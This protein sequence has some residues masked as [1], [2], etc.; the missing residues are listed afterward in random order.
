[1]TGIELARNLLQLKPG[2]PIILCTGFSETI[3]PEIAKSAGVKDLIMKPFKRRQIA[4]S[5]R[6]TLDSK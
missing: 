5:I 6:R 1:M 2:I 3:T 4:E